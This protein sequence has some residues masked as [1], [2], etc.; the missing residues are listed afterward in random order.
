MHASQ[1]THKRCH[2]YSHALDH[3][4]PVEGAA[5]RVDLYHFVAALS[6]TTC[7]SLSIRAVENIREN[8]LSLST[9]NITSDLNEWIF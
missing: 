1:G 2:L 9:L 4:L 7:L 8:R 6:M 3:L 5:H